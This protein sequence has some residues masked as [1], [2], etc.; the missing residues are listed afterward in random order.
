MLA[1][2]FLEVSYKVIW[3]IAWEREETSLLSVANVVRFLLP[4]SMTA[5]DGEREGK[6]CEDEREGERREGEGVC[7]VREKGNEQQVR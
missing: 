4:A 5:C 6:D 7:G 1:T 2:L 3:Q